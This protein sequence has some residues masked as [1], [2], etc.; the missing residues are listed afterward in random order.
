[1]S[2][3]PKILVSS[4][5]RSTERGDS[6]GGL[7]V[8]D[9]EQGSYEQVLDWKYDHI[10][11]DRGGGDRGLRGLAFYEGELYAAGARAIFVFDKDYELVRQYRHNL[12]DGTHEICIYKDMLFSISNEHDVIMMFDLKTREWLFGFKTTLGEPVGVFD[13]EAP[14]V[15]IFDENQ[16]MV[17]D[18]NDPT[19]PKWEM[20]P[21]EDTMHLDSVSLHGDWMFYS[22]S[23]AEHLYALNIKTLEHLAQKLYFPLTHNAQPWKD[24]VVFNRSV[25]SD[26]S[27][28]V[29]NELVKHWKTPTFPKPITNFSYDDH[30]RVGYTRGMVLTKDHVIVGT[31]PAS[32]HVY[33]LDHDLP[34]QSVYL[35]HD[36]RN[37]VCGMCAIE[38]PKESSVNWSM[39]DRDKI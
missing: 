1:M 6:H 36:V 29:N 16:E 31:S 24:G 9:L 3:L 21:K 11:W 37:S 8:I 4:V 18:E 33:S 26:T 17:M 39:G 32:V 20:L 23:Q 35:S 19:I 25:E 10:N 30:A 2:E 7:Y 28:Q 14:M 27:Y 22:G 34:V 15:P 5:I 12:L 13:T 38:A